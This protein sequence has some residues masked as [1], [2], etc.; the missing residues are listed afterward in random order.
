MGRELYACGWLYRPHDCCER[1]R[2]CQVVLSIS[3]W[4]GR[5]GSCWLSRAA[6]KEWPK[7]LP[8]GSGRED[9]NLRPQ[10]PERCALTGLRHSPRRRGSYHDRIVRRK[11]FRNI[12]RDPPLGGVPSSSESVRR[13]RLA[14]QVSGYDNS[15]PHCGLSPLIAVDFYCCLERCFPGD[16]ISRRCSGRR[17]GRLASEIAYVRSLEGLVIA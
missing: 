2:W 10:R 8:S 13:V 4:S 3:P 12:R 16:A 7:P 14:A 5:D 15:V 6:K 1:G 17:Y 9:S 11:L